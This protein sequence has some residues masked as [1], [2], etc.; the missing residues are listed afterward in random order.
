MKG[1]LERA[2]VEKPDTPTPQCL[3]A[4]GRNSGHLSSVSVLAATLTA[5]LMQN[6]FQK[7]AT[8]MTPG[9][10]R[11]RP[12]HVTTH[13]SGE[14]PEEEA[15]TSSTPAPTHTCDATGLHLPQTRSRWI[16]PATV[17]RCSLSVV[18]KQPGLETLEI[19][20]H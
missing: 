11:L 18:Y 3:R 7:C 13:M 9:T 8:L 1:R 12:V 19:Q 17:P 4:V 14:Q 2:R 15:N 20:L 10:P 16:L 6:R 5:A